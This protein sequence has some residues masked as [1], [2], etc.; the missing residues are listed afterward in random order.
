MLHKSMDLH[1]LRSIQHG[2]H[3]AVVAPESGFIQDLR[4]RLFGQGS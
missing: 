3:K 1:Y 4:S 2:L